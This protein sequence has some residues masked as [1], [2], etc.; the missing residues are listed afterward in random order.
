MTNRLANQPGSRFDRLMGRCAAAGAVMLLMCA[1]S[2]Q[3]VTTVAKSGD[4]VSSSASATRADAASPRPNEKQ[5]LDDFIHYVNIDNR[6]AAAGFARELLDRKLTPLQFS[7]L[8]ES[9]QEPSRFDRAIGKAMRVASLEPLAAQMQRAFEDGKLTQVRSPDEV[10]ANLKALS[11]PGS[12]V[13][14]R[15]IARKRLI[16]AGEY[17]MPQALTALLDRNNP[18][19]Q[20]EVSRLMIDM[21]RQAVIP[22]ST[23]LSK[24]EPAHQE[25]VADILGNINY[26]ASLPFLADLEATSK[27]DSVKA[28]ARR[29]MERQG[30]GGGDPATLYRELAEAYYLEKAEVTSFPGEE[31][32]ILWS[33]EP[34][35][36]LMMTQ[37]RTPVYHEAM[38]MRLAERTLQLRKED[39]AALALWIASNFKRE[40]QTPQGYANPAYPI[41]AGAGAGGRREAMYYAVAAGSSINQRVLGRAIDTNNSPLARKAIAAIEQTAGDAGIWGDG[42]GDRRAL[43]EAL[44]YPN[45]RVQYDAALALAAAQPTKMFTGAERVVPT[46]SGA[47]RDAS[48]QYALVVTPQT[49]VYQGLRKIL[50]KGGFKVLPAAATIA[51]AAAPIAE[52]PALDLVVVHSISGDR[53]PELIEAVRNTSKISATPVMALTSTEAY[54]TLNRR[55]DRDP[56]VA[57]RQAAMS[58]ELTVR[59]IYALIDSASGGPIS[60]SEAASYSSRALGALRDLAISGNT[61]LN[62]S[63]AVLP[64]VGALGEAKGETKLRI[65]EVLSRINQDRAQRAIMDAAIG[66][67]GDDRVRLL[68][69]VASSAKRYG[70]LLE[71]RHVTRISEFAQSNT[72]AEAT[73]AAALMGALNLP[74]ERLVPL[75]IGK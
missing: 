51:D 42:S 3:P 74:N 19:L 52:T 41:A 40:T 48:S 4:P 70:N 33:F 44:T 54:H 45:R 21:G 49:E 55:Y 11:G 58:E 53:I 63:D 1:A 10:A 2:G 46:L 27:V 38:A 67:S 22:L 62:V 26:R 24:L 9:M 73:A 64:L 28:A 8:V 66:A 17:A 5:L 59:A 30:S 14:G 39:Q 72:S 13:R 61:V 69:S 18:A 50:E 6:E 47:I 31:H 57:I 12:T 37:I 65:A 36:G 68:G 35:Q 60:P 20:A 75:I 23:A 43:L 29:A 71:S 25:A 32:Q 7:K 15:D 34:G 16:A 56:T